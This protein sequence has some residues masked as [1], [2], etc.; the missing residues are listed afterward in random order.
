MFLYKVIRC[1]VV[2]KIELQGRNGKGKFVL[3]D[4]EDYDNLIKYKWYTQKSGIIYGYFGFNKK[5]SIHRFI[6]KPNSKSVQIDHIDQNR[7]NNQKSNLRFCTNQQNACNQRKRP[8]LICSSKY[9][10]VSYSKRDIKWRAY[11]VQNNKQTHVGYF[12]NEIDAAEHADYYAIKLFG[13]FA[14]LNFPDKNYSNFMDKI[15]RR[16]KPNINKEVIA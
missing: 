10:N 9:K 7:L 2:K 4:D 12:E 1:L 15:K 16:L 5:I 3:V 13:E 11:I 14:C 6:M 8:S